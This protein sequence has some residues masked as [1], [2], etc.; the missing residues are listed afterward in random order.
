MALLMLMAWGGGEANGQDPWGRPAHLGQTGGPAQQ[1][2][3][4]PMATCGFLTHRGRGSLLT[5]QSQPA[6][7]SPVGETTPP[8]S[9]AAPAS[10]AAPSPWGVPGSPG[11]GPHSTGLGAGLALFHTLGPLW[12]LIGMRAPAAALAGSPGPPGL[13]SSSHHLLL[14]P[15]CTPGLVLPSRRVPGGDAVS[16]VVRPQR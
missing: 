1:L 15:A 9:P 2:R 10:E 13:D 16:P 12:Q 11:S 8:S 14:G 5:H 3:L 6:V 4:D 7:T